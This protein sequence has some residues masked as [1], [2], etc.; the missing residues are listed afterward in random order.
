M[1]DKVN[2]RIFTMYSAEYLIIYIHARESASPKTV[3]KYSSGL[4]LWGPCAHEKKIIEIVSFLF[5]LSS[6]FQK[7]RLLYEKNRL[8]YRIPDK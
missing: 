7:S 3:I 2:Y 5:F 1:A 8:L 6:F 4:E